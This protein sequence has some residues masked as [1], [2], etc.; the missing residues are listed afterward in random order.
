MTMM[1]IL[2]AVLEGVVPTKSASGIINLA[3]LVHQTDK[4][5]MHQTDNGLGIWD[6]GIAVQLVHQ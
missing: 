2:R 3:I 1:N 6:H 4:L 5:A